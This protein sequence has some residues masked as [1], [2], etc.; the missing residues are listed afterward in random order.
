MHHA[1]IAAWPRAEQEREELR[2][3]VARGDPPP[4]PAAV[5]RR[6]GPAA[7]RRQRQQIAE[8]LRK[9]L[10]DEDGM[11]DSEDKYE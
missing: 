9:E 10:E 8:A 3:A 6:P 5:P 7:M 1:I 11:W 4:A 2:Q